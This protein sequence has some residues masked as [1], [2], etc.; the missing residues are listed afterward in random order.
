[1]CRLIGYLDATGRDAC[2]AEVGGEMET[3]PVLDFPAGY[4]L[5]A[6]DRFPKQGSEEPWHLI[7]NYLADSKYLRETKLDDGTMRFFTA[8]PPALEEDRAGDLAAV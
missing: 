5:R 4:V 3:R 8:A 2:V 7:Q 1:M 6:I